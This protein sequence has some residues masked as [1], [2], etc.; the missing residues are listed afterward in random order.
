MIAFFFI[1]VLIFFCTRAESYAA[2]FPSCINRGGTDSG[3]K[4]EWLNQSSLPY[5]SIAESAADNNLQLRF[6]FNRK[7]YQYNLFLYVMFCNFLILI[8]YLLISCNF[9]L[10]FNQ[11]YNLSQSILKFKYIKI[12]YRNMYWSISENVINSLIVKQ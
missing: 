2:L 9:I 1:S 3:K 4:N 11:N 7:H 12:L 5:A 10:I 6:Q 8:K